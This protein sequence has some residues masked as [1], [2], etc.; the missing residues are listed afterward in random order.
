LSV[1][2]KMT[3][4]SSERLWNV[5]T[6]RVSSTVEADDPGATA[7]AV[8]GGVCPTAGGCAAGGVLCANAEQQTKVSANNSATVFFKYMSGLLSHIIVFDK[9]SSIPDS[10][11][12]IT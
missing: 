6:G 8:A 1:T 11:E 3:F 4:T 12:K 9:Q 10:P 5:C 7:F 2:V